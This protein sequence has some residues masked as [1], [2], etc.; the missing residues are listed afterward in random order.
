MK[1]STLLLITPLALAI[2]FTPN[3]AQLHDDPDSDALTQDQ[4][5]DQG[6]SQGQSQGHAQPQDQD[7]GEAIK[8]HVLQNMRPQTQTQTQ[9]QTHQAHSAPTSTRTT[10]GTRTSTRTSTRTK[11]ATPEQ[12]TSTTSPE[13]IDPS[14]SPGPEDEDDKNKTTEKPTTTTDKSN[15]SP[16]DNNDEDESGLTSAISLIPNPNATQNP[17]TTQTCPTGRPSKQCCQSIESVADSVLQP[18]GQLVPYLSGVDISSLLALECT[19]MENTDPN[20]NCFNSVMCCEGTPG[21]RNPLPA[22]PSLTH[23]R[24]L[25]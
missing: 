1:L 8:N 12:T 14:P 13:D 20:A 17:G 11:G 23:P 16:K 6:Q 3:P 4:G 7:P 9:T 5:Q 2:P 18:L 24:I 19:G 22:L 15:S 25:Q 10:T 21:V